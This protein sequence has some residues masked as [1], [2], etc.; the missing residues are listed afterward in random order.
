MDDTS[1]V[2][3]ELL[4]DLEC[5]VCT[6]YMV[7]P[8]KVC[9]N[10]HP[11]CSKCRERVQ[12]CPTCRAEHSEIRN[13]TLEDF[14]RKVKYPCAN[15]HSGCLQLFSIEHINEHQAVCAYGK[16]KCPLHLLNECSWK[17]LKNDLKEHVKA[18]HPTY[19]VKKS[20]FLSPHLSSGVGFLYRFGELFTYYK[21][22]RFGRSYCAVQLIGT[23]SEAAKYKYKLT[24]RAA[25]GIEQISKTFLVHG[26]SEDFETIF[27]SG[28]CLNLDEGTIHLFLEGTEVKFYIMLS[29]V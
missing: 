3:E 12:H 6:E 10:G 27:N 2:S 19:I 4:H 13:V 21:Q 24:L 7:P 17:G 15:R 25:N 23:S 29:K 14:I 22:I 5:P 9:T 1:V 28:R 11:I 16:I 8:I 18:A 20:S 26:Y